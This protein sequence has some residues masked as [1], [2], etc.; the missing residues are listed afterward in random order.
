MWNYYGSTHRL[1]HVLMVL[2]LRIFPY[3]LR[4]LVGRP[5]P[6]FWQVFLM[7][8]P[9]FSPLQRMEIWRFVCLATRR[10][11]SGR[12]YLESRTGNCIRKWSVLPF[13]WSSIFFLP[14][15]KMIPVIYLVWLQGCPAIGEKW[16]GNQ[17]N[18]WWVI[19]HVQV[20]PFS[21]F[22]LKLY[23]QFSL[24]ASPCISCHHP[25]N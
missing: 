18:D 23:K 9:V 21:P 20:Y 8:A 15:F 11:R 24:F 3:F 22:L 13:S 7:C 6:S 17:G 14:N 16:R 10:F 25:V 4:N 19:R 1:V 2:F 5:S 12:K